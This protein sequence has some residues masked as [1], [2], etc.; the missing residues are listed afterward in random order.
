VAQRPRLHMGREDGHRFSARTTFLGLRNAV[1]AIAPREESNHDAEPRKNNARF[2]RRARLLRRSEFERVYKLGRRHF[3]ASMTVF[4]LQRP[5]ADRI[6][7]KVLPWP[8]PRVGFTVSRALGG[9]VQRNRM[10]RRLR[11]AVGRQS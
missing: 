2:P 5:E 7:N 3:S 10:K 4:Y 11:A 6:D 8:G 9:A 1:S